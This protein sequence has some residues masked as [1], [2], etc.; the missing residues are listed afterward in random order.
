MGSIQGA[1]DPATDLLNVA[2]PGVLDVRI[3]RGR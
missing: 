1:E 2:A 3:A